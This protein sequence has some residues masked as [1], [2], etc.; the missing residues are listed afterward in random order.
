MQMEQ[1]ET[2]HFQGRLYPRYSQ[3]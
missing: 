1:A 2:K 3:G